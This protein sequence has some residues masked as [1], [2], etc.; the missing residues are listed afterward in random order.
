[1]WQSSAFYA[2]SSHLV[3]SGGGLG[4]RED[5]ISSES[6]YVASAGSVLR[7]H[8]LLASLD[9]LEHAESSLLDVGDGLLLLLLERL[10]TLLELLELRLEGGLSVLHL[11]LSLGDLSIKLSSGEGHGALDLLLLLS[12]AEVEVGRAAGRSEV[13]LR[14]GLEVLEGAAALVVLH[15]V[16]ITVL[17]G[18]VSLDTELAAKVLVDSA[19]DVGNEGGL[20]VLEFFHELV[21][22]RL[23]GFAV[24]SPRREELDENGLPRGE[25]VEVVGGEFGGAHGGH[26]G[27]EGVNKSQKY[28]I[29]A[30]SA[31]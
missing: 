25:G 16:R 20:R 17:D 12:V 13:L 1:M 29:A 14:E 6:H 24:A 21:P 18:R 31:I 3:L 10:I 2:T 30:Y 9:R 26:E 15:V 23:H 27:E 11:L 22:S 5:Q 8:L 4:S 19:V 28:R 7:Q